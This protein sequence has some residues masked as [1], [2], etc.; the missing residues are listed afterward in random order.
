MRYDKDSLI[1]MLVQYR[2]YG[3]TKTLM[4]LIRSFIPK[5]ELVRLI[6]KFSNSRLKYIA[7][8]ISCFAS[9][10]FVK[11][12]IHLHLQSEKMSNNLSR[13][14]GFWFDAGDDHFRLI[15]F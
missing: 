13:L 4:R 14:N 2:I 3:I 15:R 1:L 12:F 8:E 10:M 9:I 7:R 11:I 5:Y 6:K